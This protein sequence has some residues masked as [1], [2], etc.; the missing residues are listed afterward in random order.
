MRVRGGI[1]RAGV[2]AVV[3]RVLSHGSQALADKR[4]S[5]SNKK[6]M[7]QIG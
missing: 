2:G 7:E 1:R 6:R 3:G 4:R 5:A